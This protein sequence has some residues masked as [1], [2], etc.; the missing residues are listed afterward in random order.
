MGDVDLEVATAILAGGFVGWWIA[1]KSGKTQQ[2]RIVDTFGLGPFLMYMATR[3]EGPPGAKFALGFAGAAT[4]TFNGR[5]YVRIQGEQ[6][7]A[8]INR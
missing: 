4:V 6:D 8:R 2:I 3:V 7:A 1:N 5:N